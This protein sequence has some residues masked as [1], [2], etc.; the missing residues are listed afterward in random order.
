MS[1]FCFL[2]IFLFL[3][4]SPQ[5]VVVS[6]RVDDLL[7]CEKAE[8]PKKKSI[9]QRVKASTIASY[10]GKLLE[11]EV[12]LNVL[13]LLPGEALCY[14]YGLLALLALHELLLLVRDC[15]ARLV[16]TV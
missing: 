5:F 7:Y 4:A 13:Y 16:S 10:S 14:L 9:F 6:G 11:V 1:I 3:E 12:F 8:F 15:N 2:I